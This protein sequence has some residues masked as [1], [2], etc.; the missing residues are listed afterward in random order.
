MSERQRERVS[1]KMATHW[2]AADNFHQ[3]RDEARRLLSS[4]VPPDQVSWSSDLEQP[5][6]FDDHA[7]DHAPAAASPPATNSIFTVPSKFIDM[8]RHVACHHDAGRWELLY[9]TLWR[10]KHGEPHLMEIVTDG[11][12][13]RLATME[14]AVTRDLHK[15]KAFVRFR[16]TMLGDQEVY[17]AWHRPDHRI[18]RLAAPF[19]AR[20]FSG[21]HWSILTPDESV[22]WDQQQLHHGPG[23]SV[24]EAPSSD[25][26]EQLWRTYYASIFNPARLKVSAM[27]R[28]MPVRHWRT[29]P[30]TTLI[31][32]LLRQANTRVNQ[33]IDSKSG[34]EQTA[35]AFLPEKVNLSSLIKAAN[36]CTAC[37]LYRDATQTVFGEG[38]QKAQLVL[39]GEQPG[40]REDLEGHPFVGPAGVLLDEAL[41]AAGVQ[42]DEVYITNVVKHFKFTMRGKRRLHQKPNSREITAC[43]PWLEAELGMIKPKALVCLGATS[44]QA[45]L[46]RDF[47]ITQRR[48]QMIETDWC[49]R[50]LATW[51]P[52][53][54][55]RMPDV[56]RREEMREQLVSDLSQVR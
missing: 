45:L 54:I 53:A 1:S 14:K 21:M 50:T 43:R 15:M 11:D 46:G 30:E 35:A 49:P 56:T 26:L 41:E 16:K 5:T 32:E 38:P 22:S 19:F 51:H 24:T 23:A 55:L 25:V 28:E 42:R 2:I 34:S 9:R 44:A 17:I 8:A 7:A 36:G 20:R 37:E 31:P 10:L 6:L 13:H 52:A 27:K 47:R 4:D 3:W 40:D 33:M 29:L 39:V 48:G 12:I 18:V